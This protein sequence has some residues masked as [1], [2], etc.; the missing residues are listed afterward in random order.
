MNDN[1]KN[2][3]D[4]LDSYITI[5]SGECTIEQAKHIYKQ[6][7][8]LDD[9]INYSW[10][11]ANSDHLQFMLSKLTTVYKLLPNEACVTNMLLV[12]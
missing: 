10:E 2:T 1:I 3:I 8:Q 7:Y 11:V 5:L 6:A 12:N 4:D 9:L